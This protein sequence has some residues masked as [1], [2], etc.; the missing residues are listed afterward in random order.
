MTTHKTF[1][2]PGVP[3]LSEPQATIERIGGDAVLAAVAAS[4][5]ARTAEVAGVGLVGLLVCPPALIDLA[6]H[7]TVADVRKRPSSPARHE[8]GPLSGSAA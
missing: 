4:D 5:T 7:R 8:T 3:D 6:P 1:T 2:S